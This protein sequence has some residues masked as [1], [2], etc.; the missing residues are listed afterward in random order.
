MTSKCLVT[1]A[2]EVGQTAK[3]LVFDNIIK[4]WMRMYAAGRTNAVWF[5]NSDTLLQLMTMNMAVG[6]G[7]I[8]VYMPA[9]GLAGQPYGTLFG[10]P[11]IEI[12]HCQTLGTTGDVILADLSQ[13]YLGRKSTDIESASSIHLRFDYGETA[14]RWIVRVDGQPSWSSDITPK[15]GS[16]TVSPIVA[17]ATRA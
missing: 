4:M 11:V 6:T 15:N 14:F 1:V 5:I 13:Y 3:T 12:E 16:N 9:N 17:L 7:G 2:K 8:P 10:R